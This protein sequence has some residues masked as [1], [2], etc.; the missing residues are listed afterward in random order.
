MQIIS[1]SELHK[2]DLEEN[3]DSYKR[4]GKEKGDQVQR[5]MMGSKVGSQLRITTLLDSYENFKANEGESLDDVYDRFVMLMNELRTN[6]IDKKEIDYN[7]K[8]ISNLQPEW[9]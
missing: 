3:R 8:K 5:I 2:R 1:Y 6:K 7:V 9:R 4:S